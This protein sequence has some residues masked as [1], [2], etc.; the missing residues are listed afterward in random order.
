MV[1]GRRVTVRSLECGHG[2][3]H[4]GVGAGDRNGLVAALEVVSD[5]MCD[6]L[7]GATK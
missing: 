2:D 6:V 4:L 7:K 1:V 3:N 5:S